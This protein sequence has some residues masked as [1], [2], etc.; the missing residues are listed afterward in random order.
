MLANK[1]QPST[2]PLFKSSSD[3][4]TPRFI[5]T[6]LLMTKFDNTMLYRIYLTKSDIFIGFQNPDTGSRPDI[7]DLGWTYLMYQIYLTHQIYPTQPKS[8]ELDSEFNG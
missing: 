1:R 3:P 8:T 7:S 4:T 2:R 5:F 6:D